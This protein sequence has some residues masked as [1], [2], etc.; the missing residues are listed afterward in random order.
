MPD[1]P[2]KFPYGVLECSPHT[3][4]EF[5]AEIRLLLEHRTLTPRT[6]VCVNAHIYNLACENEDL[7]RH[8]NACRVVAADGMAIVWTARWFG[9]R[10]PE[11]CNMTE[12]FRAFLADASMPPSRAILIGC[13]APEAEAARLAINGLSRHCRVVQSISGFLSDAEYRQILT[14]R[15]DIDFILLGMGTPRTE[16]FAQLAS[17]LCPRAVVWSVGGGTIMILAGKEREAPVL[18]RR[19]GVQWLY[20]LLSRP[21]PFWRRYLFGNPRFVLRI[22]RAAWRQRWAPPA[23]GRPSS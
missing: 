4:A 21:G 16:R 6:L 15:D 7:R 5:L 17:S 18:W 11:R 20:R 19:L 14:G 9:A 8:L 22:A 3:L 10:V 2:R 23:P 12:A 13:P 1:G